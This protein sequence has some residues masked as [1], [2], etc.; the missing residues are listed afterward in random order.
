MWVLLWISI[1]VLAVRICSDM[2]NGIIL[3]S[4]FSVM[5]Q[6]KGCHIILSYPSSSQIFR[7]VG[8]LK[9]LLT[10]GRTRGKGGGGTGGMNL[11]VRPRVNIGKNNYKIIF[12]HLSAIAPS[13]D[14]IKMFR[15]GKSA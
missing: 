7:E 12:E 11:R 1:R 9:R 15:Y 6:S 10:H 13:R 3:N 2:I 4:K 8:L 14:K 5:I